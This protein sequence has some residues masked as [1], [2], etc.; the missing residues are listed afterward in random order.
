MW[1][2][3]KLPKSAQDA[4]VDILETRN[5]LLKASDFDENGLLGMQPIDH[6]AQIFFNKG[7]SDARQSIISRVC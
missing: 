6:A 5:C 7:T 1:E 3:Y 2:K 4:V